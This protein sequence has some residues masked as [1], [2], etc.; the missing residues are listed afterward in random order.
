[1]NSVFIFDPVILKSA[2]YQDR[3]KFSTQ[4]EFG[5]IW[6]QPWSYAPLSNIFFL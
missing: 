6:L 3:H 2:D 4:F 1:M 5:Q